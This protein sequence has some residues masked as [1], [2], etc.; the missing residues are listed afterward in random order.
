MTCFLL[1]TAY[2]LVGALT[3]FFCYRSE[4]KPTGQVTIGDLFGLLVALFLWPIFWLGWLIVYG[5]DDEYTIWR[6]K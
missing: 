4:V 6:L 5:I 3:V 2:F 1:A